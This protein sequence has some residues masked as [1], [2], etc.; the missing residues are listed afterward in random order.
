MAWTK[1]E[2]PQTKLQWNR[3]MYQRKYRQSIKDYRESKE[4]REQVKANET[5]WIKKSNIVYNE[6]Q[7]KTITEN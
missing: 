3:M 1:E 4:Y 5:I 6:L 2:Q 7:N